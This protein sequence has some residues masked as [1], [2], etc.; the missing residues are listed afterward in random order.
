VSRTKGHVIL[1]THRGTL[2]PMATDKRERQRANREEK[3]AAE[4]KAKRRRDTWATIKKW[5]IYGVAIV[6]IFLVLTFLLNT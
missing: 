5:A 1:T 3:K 6:V 4:A 2:R